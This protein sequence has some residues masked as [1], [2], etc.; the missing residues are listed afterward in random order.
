MTRDQLTLYHITQG[1]RDEIVFQSSP[2]GFLY[3][4]VLPEDIANEI[5]GTSV[6]AMDKNWSLLWNKEICLGPPAAFKR[7]PLD[8]GDIQIFFIYPMRCVAFDTES[9]GIKSP[10]EITQFACALFHPCESWHDDPECFERIVCPQ[11]YDF[12]DYSECAQKISGLTVEIVQ[13]GQP[14]GSVWEE[15]LGYLHNQFSERSA[16]ADEM[17]GRLDINATSSSVPYQVLPP[18]LW[19]AHNNFKFD[20]P[21][22]AMTLQKNNLTWMPHWH[23]ADSLAMFRTLYMTNVRFFEWFRDV[24]NLKLGTLFQYS[25]RALMSS[26]KDK[27]PSQ[28]QPP[29][30][31]QAIVAHTADSDVKM[32]VILIKA[33]MAVTRLSC[34]M[35]FVSTLFY[36]G[37]KLHQQKGVAI[38]S[39][40]AV[41]AT[42]LFPIR[43][44][45]SKRGRLLSKVLWTRFPCDLWMILSRHADWASGL[46]DLESRLQVIPQGKEIWSSLYNFFQSHAKMFNILVK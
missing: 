12:S 28:R 23:L 24:P 20:A 1:P 14:F 7:I 33:I 8:S 29:E 26:Q 44:I 22:L 16:S 31:M 43:G 25:I 5:F 13:Q 40:H 41:D 38:S 18:L 11:F 30:W 35:D 27:K 9:T 39:Y 46:S 34:D 45:A 10:I 15:L 2:E 21:L 3:D 36:V 17:L 4:C 32:L 37:E 19:F 42:R 6:A